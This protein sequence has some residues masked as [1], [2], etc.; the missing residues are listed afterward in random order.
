MKGHQM[1]HRRRLEANVKLRLAVIGCGI[2]A[3]QY[4][5]TWI[6]RDDLEIVAIADTNTLALEKVINIAKEANKQAPK[7]FSD[8]QSMLRECHTDL[9][10]AYICTPHASHGEQAIDAL[11]HGLHVLLEKPMVTSVA[12]ARSLQDAQRYSGKELVVAYQGGLSPLV[13][14][15]RHDI[16]MQ[17]YGPLVSIA[18]NIW[19][20][21][22]DT[23]LGHWKQ[24]PAVSGGG[25]MFDTGAHMMNTVS[26]L[27]NQPFAS[28]SARMQKREYP[29]D[30]V[31][32]VSAEL[33][34]GTLVTLHACGQTIACTSRIECYFPEHLVRICAWGRWLEIEDKEGR[35]TRQEQESANNLLNVFQQTLTQQITNPSDIRQGLR[36]AQLW[37][38]VKNSAVQGGKAVSCL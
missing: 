22:A 12:E 17:T 9:N 25:F 19:E 15:L 35:V 1:I 7:C 30:I 37:D 6:G 8:W 33:Q 13:Q 36:M 23:Y 3:T 31:T 2:K 34:D 11:N 4:I 21:W 38:A 32:A 28:V 20:N 24:L 29:V 27:A 26:V 18:A 5:Q 10:A 14:Q 16:Q